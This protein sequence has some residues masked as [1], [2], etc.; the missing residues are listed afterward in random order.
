MHLGQYGCYGCD[1]GSATVAAGP[2]EAKFKGLNSGEP[3]CAVEESSWDP[4]ARAAVN[5]WGVQT[6]RVQI[7][8]WIEHAIKAWAWQ[9]SIVR[10]TGTYTHSWTGAC[11]HGHMGN[12]ERSRGLM[13][14]SGCRS[15][16]VVVA[17]RRRPH[18][19]DSRISTPA[20]LLRGPP[21]QRLARHSE[22]YV[23]CRACRLLRWQRFSAASRVE[24]DGAGGRAARRANGRA[25]GCSGW[26]SGWDGGDGGQRACGLVVGS[27]QRR[28]GGRDGTVVMM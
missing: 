6:A 4:G 14:A 19:Q 13:L 7:H 11:R 27:G 1:C 15:S 12:W 3:R 22:G 24:L 16:V 26:G 18:R 17:R 9:R 20:H 5:G 8:E 10:F 2:V 21:G 23:A 28:P 25:R